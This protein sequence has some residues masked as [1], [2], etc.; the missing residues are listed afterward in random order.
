M[1]LIYTNQ[2]II[3]L[4]EALEFIAPKVTHE[5]LIEIRDKILDA[6]DT[7]IEQPL[8]GQTEPYLEHL[9]L[10]H[11]RI[12]ESHYKIIYR[13]IGECIYITDIFDSRQD[14]GTMKG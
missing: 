1:K 13:I 11:R 10:K 9:G 2:A 7:L 8:Q 4:E 3:S 6:A 12:I 5:K 14:P